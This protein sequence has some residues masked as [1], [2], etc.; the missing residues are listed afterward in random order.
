LVKGQFL[1]LI[2][3]ATKATL[4]VWPAS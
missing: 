3:K 1:I 2:H 4:P